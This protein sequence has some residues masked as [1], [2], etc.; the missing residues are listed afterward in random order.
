V[1]VDV[2]PSLPPTTP[3]YP[4][5]WQPGV[6]VIGRKG[7][8]GWIQGNG[9]KWTVQQQG[10]YVTR[11]DPAYWTPFQAPLVDATQR[12]RIAFEAGAALYEAFGAGGVRH[13]TALTDDERI[14]GALPEAKFRSEL[15]GLRNIVVAAVKAALEPYMGA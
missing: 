13:W 12:D 14:N 11:P 15:T 8:V 4:E 9:D 7:E 5:W 1:A 10:C 6:Q 2:A 3:A